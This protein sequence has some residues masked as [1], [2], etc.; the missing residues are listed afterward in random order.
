MTSDDPAVRPVRLPPPDLAGR[1]IPSTSQSRRSWFRVHQTKFPAKFFSLNSN[2]RFSHPNCPYP[3][4]Y[5]AMDTAT[6]LFERFGDGMYDRKLAI[7]R[8]VWEA[9]SVSSFEVPHFHVCDLT[10]A[11]TLSALMVDLS[12]LMNNQLKTPQ[13]WGLAVQNHPANFQGIKFQS[14]FN[15]KSC[16][17]LFG[18][19]DVEDRIKATLI[20]SLSSN[21]SAGDWLHDHRVSLY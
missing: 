18:R 20:G 21:D 13:E 7:P 16:L 3:F 14:R 8:S 11:R 5:L 10:N 12:A 1:K 6:C 17:A 2:H 4:L 15:H 19:D 9:H